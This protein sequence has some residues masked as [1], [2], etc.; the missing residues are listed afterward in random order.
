MEISPRNGA[1]RLL[2]WSCGRRQAW[3]VDDAAEALDLTLRAVRRALRQLLDQGFVL[4][5]GEGQYESAIK[6]RRMR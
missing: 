5:L 4:D 2:R 1:V 6:W 3:R